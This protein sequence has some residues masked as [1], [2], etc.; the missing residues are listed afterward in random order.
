MAAAPAPAPAQTKGSCPEIIASLLPKNGSLR[1]GAYNAAGPMGMGNGSADLPFD[2]PCRKS[3]KFPA[4]ISVAVTYYGGEM[5]EMLKMQ[6]DAVNQQTLEDAMRGLKRTSAPPYG[7]SS[8]AARSSTSPTRPNASRRRSTPERTLNIRRPPRQ[9]QGR[10][11]YGQRPPGGRTRRHD[12]PRSRQGG[13][14]RGLREPQEGGLRKSQ[15]GLGRRAGRSLPPVLSVVPFSTMRALVAVDCQQPAAGRACVTLGLAPQKSRAAPLL[16]I[17]QV[18]DEAIVMDPGIPRFDGQQALA[19]EPVT[20]IA[21]VD[22]PPGQLGTEAFLMHTAPPA[23]PTTRA[24]RL[25]R[26]LNPA[27]EVAVH[28]AGGDELPAHE[29]SG[30]LRLHP[31]PGSSG[32]RSGSKGDLSDFPRRP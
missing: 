6:G 1:G 31:A 23:R 28:A 3:E 7:R 22:L 5:A 11:A 16:N 18:L 20:C 17:A 15:V 27:A 4:R 30:P 2:H 8:A 26:V 12:H 13:G 24:V 9:A 19:G 21:K 25:G 32:N 14:A 10:G 29:R